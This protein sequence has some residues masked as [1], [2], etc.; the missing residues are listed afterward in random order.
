LILPT[1]VFGGT[2]N[3]NGSIFTESDK[4]DGDLNID[5]RPLRIDFLSTVLSFSTLFSVG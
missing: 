5:R 3:A 1:K 4:A 2:G